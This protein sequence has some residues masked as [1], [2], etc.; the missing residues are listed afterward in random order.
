MYIMQ[1]SK[2]NAEVCPTYN[3]RTKPS[4]VDLLRNFNDLLAKH[5]MKL[6]GMWNDHPGHMVYNIYETPNM[7]AFA[8]FSME[9]EM[10]AWL[11][12]NTVETKVV[13]GPDEVMQMFGLK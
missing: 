10:M 2:H 9:P 13:Y 1:I 5:G 11:S 3:D 6:A 8:A 7:D 12:Y 4:T